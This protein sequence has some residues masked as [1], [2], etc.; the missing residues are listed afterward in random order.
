M[1]QKLKL[2]DPMNTGMVSSANQLKE[3]IPVL[4]GIPILE[5]HVCTLRQV[6]HSTNV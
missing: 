5:V 3:H 1:S 6:L 4:L 2:V